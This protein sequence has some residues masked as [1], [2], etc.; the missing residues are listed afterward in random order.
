MRQEGAFG[1]PY[2]TAAPTRRASRPSGP[3]AGGRIRFT[4]SFPL[5]S[6]SREKDWKAGWPEA[7][8]S[9]M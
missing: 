6:E 5:P 4:V 7:A 1:S 9:F 3:V 2:S 8:S